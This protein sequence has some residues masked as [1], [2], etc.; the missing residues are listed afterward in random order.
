MCNVR[1]CKTL[2]Y[3]QL[4][5]AHPSLKPVDEIRSVPGAQAVPPLVQP[6]GGP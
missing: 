6:T 1:L 3:A 4:H 2:L 5:I